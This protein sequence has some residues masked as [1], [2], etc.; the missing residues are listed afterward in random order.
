MRNSRTAM[1]K[2]AADYELMAARLRARPGATDLCCNN[3]ASI[4]ILFVIEKPFP[5]GR[6]SAI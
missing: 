6:H 4:S 5:Y 1:L 2:I 3:L